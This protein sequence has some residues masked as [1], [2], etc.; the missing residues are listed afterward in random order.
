MC[1]RVVFQV[2]DTELMDTLEGERVRCE[3]IVSVEEENPSGVST[4]GEDHVTPYGE[5]TSMN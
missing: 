4:G 3:S 2:F 5:V 1:G